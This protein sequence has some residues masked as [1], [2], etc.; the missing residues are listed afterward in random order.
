MQDGTITNLDALNESIT[1]LNSNIE[2]ILVRFAANDSH[3]DSGTQNT[4]VSTDQPLSDE[5][6]DQLRSVLASAPKSV[7]DQIG[8][9]FEIAKLSELKSSDFESALARCTELTAS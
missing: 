9:E 6:L 3:Y 8:K 4:E 5:Q 1:L 7:I 2:K